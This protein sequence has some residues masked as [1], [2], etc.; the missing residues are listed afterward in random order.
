MVVRL[1]VWCTAQAEGLQQAAAA[2][3]AVDARLKVCHVPT[4]LPVSYTKHLERAG[5][6]FIVPGNVKS[7]V[8]DQRIELE[9]GYILKDYTPN[10]TTVL[11]IA[12]D[13]DYVRPGS[14]LR[15]LKEQGFHV[16][17]VVPDSVCRSSAH[18]KAISDVASV[19]CAWQG[20]VLAGLKGAKNVKKNNKKNRKKMPPPSSKLRVGQAYSGR[21]IKWKDRYG[22]IS[23]DGDLGT[24]FVHHSAISDEQPS[25]Q[26]RNR[27]AVKEPVSF[28]LG[29]NAKGFIALHVTRATKPLHLV[30]YRMC[31]SC[32][33]PGPRE[34]FSGNQWNLPAKRR[35]C[36]ECIDIAARK[37]KK[38]KK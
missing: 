21:V 17:V 9:M 22:F 8:V 20:Q 2:A 35:R 6:T 5:W 32:L 13:A 27:L 12:G 31:S 10:A 19:C 26:E 25:G 29:Q 38:K 33:S 18:F 7:E 16:V 34:D 28:V 4:R 23:V 37:P 11:L 36:K 15:Q 24:V 3:V 30:G 1:R 14:P